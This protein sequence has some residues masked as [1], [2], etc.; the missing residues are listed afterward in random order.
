M[1]GKTDY[2]PL[3][4]HPSE[5]Y[6]VD[7]FVIIADVSVS[8]TDFCHFADEMCYFFFLLTASLDLIL[9]R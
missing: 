3:S 7:M 2:R 8:A 6:F 9:Q 4:R 1:A 5:Q